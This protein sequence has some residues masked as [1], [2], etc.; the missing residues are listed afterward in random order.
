MWMLFALLL[1]S[2]SKTGPMLDMKAFHSQAECEAAKPAIIKAV[3]EK[4]PTAEVSLTCFK[5]E[6]LSK[7]A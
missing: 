2:D 6:P 3:I 5:P 1:L 4:Y 7:V